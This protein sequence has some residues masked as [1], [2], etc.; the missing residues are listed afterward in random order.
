MK[1]K[2]IE[3]KNNLLL[4]PMSNVTDVAFRSIAISCGADAGSTELIS[5]KAITDFFK[6][7]QN[8]DIIK[9][10]EEAGVNMKAS[11]DEVVNNILEGKTF[12]VTGTLPTLKRE[13]ATSLIQKHGGKVSGSVSKN[14]TYL[15]AGEAAGSKL[16][17]AQDLGIN[18]ITEDELLEMIK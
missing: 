8:L 14:T 5:A 13:D 16:K 12:V 10:L 6:Q 2:N 4:A 9:R 3:F 7:P 18:I 11:S 1:I 15:L 17:K